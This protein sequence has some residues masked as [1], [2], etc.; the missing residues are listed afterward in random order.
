MLSR[1][2]VLSVSN[3]RRR[4]L[5][6]QCLA[7]LVMLC[8]CM[9][10][11]SSSNAGCTGGDGMVSMNNSAV[12][13]VL[14]SPGDSVPG[15]T[16]TTGHTTA[17]GGGDNCTLTASVVDTNRAEPA[18]GNVFNTNVS[19]VGVAFRYVS[20]RAEG[21]VTYTENYAPGTDVSNDPRLK[22]TVTG[23]S[24]Y[25]TRSSIY[26]DIIR[27]SDPLAP[28][29]LYTIQGVTLHY[30]NVDNSGGAAIPPWVQ[31]QNLTVQ[32]LAACTIVAPPPVKF[33]TVK[34]TDF[35]GPNTI[36][37]ATSVPIPLTLTCN[38]S[39]GLKAYLT[40]ANGSAIV[41]GPPGTISVTGGV[42]NLGIQILNADDV[43][44]SF[45]AGSATVL[46]NVAGTGPN[47]LDLKAQLIQTGNA[48]PTIGTFTAGATL[49][50]VYP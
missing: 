11:M 7:S 36:G 14:S 41:S 43:P 33:R 44:F 28:P 42:D 26:A 8:A 22:I 45:D 15:S 47:T 13:S 46:G 27:T 9:L 2:A 40:P 5:M 35:T 1:S 16:G 20:N 31:S 39:M 23:N 32:I 24:G 29:G 12:F 18:P 10:E 17:N 19:G 34:P 38:G 6:Q 49:T 37:T 48:L 25:Q 3:R 30:Q 50:L 21:G 4:I